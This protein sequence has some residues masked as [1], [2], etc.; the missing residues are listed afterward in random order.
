MNTSKAMWNAF[1]TIAKL[2]MFARIYL[3]YLMREK[4]WFEFADDVRN[5]KLIL[6]NHTMVP[7]KKTAFKLEQ[8]SLQA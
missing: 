8:N 3:S 7:T 1:T 2:K 6:P 5:F 4:K